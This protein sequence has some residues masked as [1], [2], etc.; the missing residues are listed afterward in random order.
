[1]KGQIR[2][3][4]LMYNNNVITFHLW[5]QIVTRS[6]QELTLNV[7]FNKMSGN[8]LNIDNNSN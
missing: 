4:I 7:N 6:K 3:F 2:Y 8:K 5:K 1:M